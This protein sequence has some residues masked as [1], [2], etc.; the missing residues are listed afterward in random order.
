MRHAAS[1]A[2]DD[3]L[4][5]YWGPVRFAFNETFAGEWTASYLSLIHI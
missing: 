1:R 3:F 4:Q 5:D 2:G